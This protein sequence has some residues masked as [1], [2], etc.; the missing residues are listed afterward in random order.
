MIRFAAAGTA[1]IVLLGPFAFAQEATPKV[2]V[3]GGFSLMHLLSGGPN[4]APLDV[5][6]REPGGT[7]KTVTNFKGWNA[8]GQYNL[9]RWLGI[10]ADFGGRYG[11]PFTALSVRKIAGLPDGTA[12]SFMAGPVIS[13]RT[14]SRLTPFV[15]LLFGVERASLRAST[16]T[17]PSGTLPSAAT[18]Y[19]DFTYAAGAGID[20]RLSQHFALRLGQLDY[21]SA[22]LNINKFYHAAFGPNIFAGPSTHQRNA[23]FSTGFVLQF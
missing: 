17:A 21:F 10:A 2:Q 18:D 22:T 12:Y 20:Y 6:L 16:I 19:T 15:H 8:E 11:S 23:R 4:G 3:F 9:D 13:Y 5:A 7:F 14:K 1:L